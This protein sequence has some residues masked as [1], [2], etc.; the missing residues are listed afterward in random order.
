MDIPL[1]SGHA[2]CKFFTDVHLERG[3]GNRIFLCACYDFRTYACDVQNDVQKERFIEVKM[4][5]R[6]W[7]SRGFYEIL[8]F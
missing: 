8:A 2:A 5:Y 3:G 1:C 7:I 4:E 6:F